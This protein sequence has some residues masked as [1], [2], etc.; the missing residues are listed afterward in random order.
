VPPTPSLL[1]CY[2]CLRNNPLPM[3]PEWNH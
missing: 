1:R 2:L 3:C